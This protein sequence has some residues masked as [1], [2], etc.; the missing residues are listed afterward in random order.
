MDSRNLGNVDWEAGHV[1]WLDKKKE[2]A[3]PEQQCVGSAAEIRLKLVVVGQ[4]ACGKTCTLI[5][6]SKGT[7]PEVY[8]PTVFENYVADV[9]VDGR[10]VE[11]GLWDTAGQE[12]YDR[13]RP[14]SYNNDTNV[15]VISFAI[16]SPDSLDDVLEKWIAE[17]LHF[18]KGIPIVLVGMKEDLRRDPKTIEELRKT[19]QAPTTYSQGLHVAKQIGAAAYVECSAKTNGGIRATFETAVRLA[20]RARDGAGRGKACLLM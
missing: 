18:C 5:V 13:I 4:G 12:D 16:D 17:V 19:S 11:L 2:F 7:F 8:V 6:F 14:L 20:L 3:A 10:H 1:S 15:V 9:E